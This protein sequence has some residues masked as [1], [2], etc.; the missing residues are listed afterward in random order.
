MKLTLIA[1][2]FAVL[3]APV[4]A[5]GLDAKTMT[6]KNL[7]AMDAKGMMAAGTAINTAMKADPKMPKMTDNEATKAAGTA[8]K[9]H[10][11]GTV[12]DAMM[13]K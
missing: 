4:F 11:D 12:M 9:A 10:G 7:M 1:A 8:C 5:A 2:A 6:C 3:A 13:K